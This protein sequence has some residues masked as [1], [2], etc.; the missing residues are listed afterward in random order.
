MKLVALTAIVALCLTTVSMGQCAITNANNPGA[1][2]TLN[3]TNGF[4][5]CSGE[6]VIMNFTS[7][8]VG[9]PFDICFGP[10]AAA[11]IPLIDDAIELDLATSYSLFGGA[12]GQGTLPPVGL[13]FGAASMDFTFVSEAGIGNLNNLQAG[14]V[15]A[16]DPDGVS[17]SEVSTYAVA[18][19]VYPWVTVGDDA[20]LDLTGDACWVDVNFYGTTYN[21]AFINSN[22]EVTFASG[23][24]DFTATYGE[25]ASG[26]PRIGWA[27][28]LEPN[29]YGSITTNFLAD[30][31]RVDYVDVAEW[32]TGGT[33]VISYSVEVSTSA[34]ASITGMIE[35]GTWGTTG[36]C[37]GASNGSLG[38]D[39]TAG[40]GVSFDAILAAGGGGM[41]LASDMWVEAAGGM[42]SGAGSSYTN[43]L[44]P[45][46]DGS[47]ISVN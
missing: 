38:T 23:T 22:G 41:G 8:Q 13:G 20:N 24:S 46:A 42:V 31:F 2:L 5:G 3:G 1:S 34:G 21:G 14:A 35:D 16:T 37:L 15:D 7:D 30:G 29:N 17:L 9:S 4:A 28:D 27:A 19:A 26:M 25:W 12:C 36:Q 6:L 33:G 18:P 32:G 45:A 40:A 11:C 47:S 10:L 44:F 39:P 43:I